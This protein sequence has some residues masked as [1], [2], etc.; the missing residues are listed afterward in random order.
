[1]KNLSF[2]EFKQLC[3]NATILAKDGYGNK[4][5]LLSDQS[6]IKL[7]RIKRLISSARV[8]SPARKFARNAEKLQRLN[9]ATIKII[10]LFKIKSIQRTAVHYQPLEGLTV[11][12]YLQS[13]TADDIFFE[14][15]GRFLACLHNHGVYF[16]SA[17]FGNIIY[18]PQQKFGL[19]DISD[20]KISPFS[21][22]QYKRL[23]N[24]KHILRLSEDL[25]LIQ[26]TDAI[27]TGYLQYSKIQTPSFKN[28]FL[29]LYQYLNNPDSE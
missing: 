13:N 23:R 10:N 26:H 15:L 20:M 14:Q 27:Q 1:M 19:I 3:Q 21:L 12:D 8:Y 7:F 25:Q 22:N 28:K 6:M 5:L 9:I 16:R 2:E 29:N 17:H 18:T 4:V 24:L 11:R